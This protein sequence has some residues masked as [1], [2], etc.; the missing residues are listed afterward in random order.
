MMTPLALVA[1]LDCV[2]DFRT[3]HFHIVFG[4]NA[5]AL[6]RLLGADHMFHCC[7]ELGRQSAVSHQH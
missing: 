7:D 6:D 1:T 2:G 3:A 5:D 4:V